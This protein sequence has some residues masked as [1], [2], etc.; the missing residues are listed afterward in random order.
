MNQPSGQEK[1]AIPRFALELPVKVSPTAGN[2][3]HAAT[4][5]DVSS[6]GVCFLCDSAVEKDSEI[7]FT[8]TLPASVTMTEPI[9]VRC[10]GK[11]V[12]VGDARG[13][14]E[15]AAAIR[16]YEFVSDEQIQNIFP[17]NGTTP[18]S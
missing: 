4:T 12:R 6:L 1:R 8:L 7:E 18:Q 14:F 9:N 10:V 3:A 17:A 11:V 5:K 13:A 15:V 16:S 2:L